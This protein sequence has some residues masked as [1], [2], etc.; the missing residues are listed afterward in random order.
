[1]IDLHT[2]TNISD[3]SL[4]PMQLMQE[5]KKTGLSAIAV[6]DHDSIDGL[7]EAQYKADC[8][9]IKL[10]KGIEFSI[11]YG[12]NRIIHILGLGIEPQS[13]EFMSIYT[14]YRQERSEKLPYVF[15]R[16][17]AM[18][19]PINQEEVEPYIAGDYMD[20]QAIAKYLVTKGYASSIKYAW[21]D[22][23]DYIDYIEGELIKPKDAF[24][25]IHAAGG[26]AFMAHF[27]L[28]IG[29]KG[30]SDEEARKILG[31]LKELGLDGLEYFYPSFTEEDQQRCARYIKDFGFLKSGGT[32][33]HGANRAHIKLGIG[34]GDFEVPD[35]LLGNILPCVG[36]SPV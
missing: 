3:G 31:A 17:N 29:L 30:Y 14:K 12:V 34:E 19:V 16:L 6:T 1:M 10:I 15:Q 25:A 18:G 28:P 23:L 5:A 7:D 36:A 24:A 9:G 22:F 27:H 20:R 4:S 32:D 2:H 21:I 11:V 8:L 13:E 33:F 26:K 35:E